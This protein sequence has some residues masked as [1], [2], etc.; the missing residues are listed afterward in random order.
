MPGAESLTWR[1]VVVPAEMP[2]PGLVAPA[3]GCRRAPVLAVS[4]ADHLAPRRTDRLAGT[5]TVRFPHASFRLVCA[6][7]APPHRT[8]R[9]APAAGRSSGDRRRAG[10]PGLPLDA[11]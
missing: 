8:C 1:P 11:W 6:A 7:R 3:G 9:P 4:G 2:E 5:V 10:A